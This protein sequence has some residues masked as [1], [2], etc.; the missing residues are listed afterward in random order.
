MT[1]ALPYALA[2]LAFY[3]FGDFIYK[4]A[5]GRGLRAD[6][7]LM[8]QAWFFLPLVVAYAW[9]TGTLVPRPAALW[10]SLAGAFVFVGF[11]N[12]IKS[13]ATGSVSINAPIFRLNFVVTAALAIVVLGEQLSVTKL[14]GLALALAA[15]WLLLGAH[16]PDERT[17]EDRAA[18][19]RVLLAT[20]SF[21]TAN[22]LHTVGLRQ[23]V[24]PE[25]MLVAQAIVFM[26]LTNLAVVVVDRRI[27]APKAAWGYGLIM[28]FVLLGAFVCLLHGVA[29]GQASVVVPIA[30]MGFIVTA[31]LGVLLLGEPL[32]PRKLLG[33][34]LA[35]GALV[36]LALRE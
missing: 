35:A 21:G 19:L 25:T 11:Y 6:H 36:A 23:G 18:M 28:S 26:P 16:A 32:T 10:G 15:T 29:L 24:V 17:H 2:A 13:L 7:L 27:A 30:Q 34:V 31:L 20:L 1:G 33:L 22:F 9:L 4:R 5:A 3:G 14:A 8:S 12:F